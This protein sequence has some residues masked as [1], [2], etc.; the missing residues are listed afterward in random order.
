MRKKLFCVTICLMIALFVTCSKTEKKKEEQKSEIEVALLEAAAIEAS[1]MLR[2]IRNCQTVYQAENDVYLECAPSPPDGGTDAV[3][4]KWV[5]AGGFEEINFRPEGR[6]LYQYAV[7]V[8]EDGKKYT[9]MAMGDVDENGV[10]VKYTATNS[11]P[12]PK[13]KPAKEY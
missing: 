3:S 6:V 7:T 5:D 1:S 8:S 9:A 12:A 4:D 11:S 2:L 13:R 10:K